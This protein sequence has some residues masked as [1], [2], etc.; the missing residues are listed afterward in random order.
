MG[1]IAL[2]GPGVPASRRRTPV[3]PRTRSHRLGKGWGG[4]AWT[5]L[6]AT[7]LLLATTAP[8][9][10]AGS[11]TAPF[12]ASSISTWSS[13]SSTGCGASSLL[14]WSSWNATLGRGMLGG[15]A[16]A[17]ITCGANASRTVANSAGNYAAGWWVEVP[18]RLLGALP[19]AYVNASWTLNWTVVDSY[20]VGR[21]CNGTLA[22][23]QTF[24]YLDCGVSAAVSFQFQEYLID[25]S[26]NAYYGTTNPI[27]PSAYNNSFAYRDTLCNPKCTHFRYSSGSAGPSHH[28]TKF[29]FS[30]SVASPAAGDSWVVLAYMTASAWAS[31][32]TVSSNFASVTPMSGHAV[33]RLDF[34]QGTNGATLQKITVV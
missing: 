29:T 21:W 32:T 14:Q 6:G 17:G 19:T 10:L 7:V 22:P 33:A 28:S 13:T 24:G 34:G 23:N 20:S 1:G 9:G 26:T 3:A 5:A 31:V 2:H 16:H 11:S 12:G 4:T 27:Y 18:V 8:L 15:V 25:T 30:F